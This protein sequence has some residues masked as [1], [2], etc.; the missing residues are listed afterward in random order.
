VRRRAEQR[1]G[2]RHPAGAERTSP[3]DVPSERVEEIR[4]RVGRGISGWTLRT[5][6]SEH[7][8]L[9]FDLDSPSGHVV[10]AAI[11]L[12]GDM[13]RFEQRD[14]IAYSHRG[15]LPHAEAQPLRRVIEL[16]HRDAQALLTP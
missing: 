7:G 4:A 15:P 2:L 8:G 3:T 13:P 16:V 10:L 1:R 14:G 11:A 12:H 9:L 5:V 6:R